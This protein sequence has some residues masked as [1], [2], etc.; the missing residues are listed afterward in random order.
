MTDDYP[1]AQAS[2]ALRREG[3]NRHEHQACA[4]ATSRS[5]PV[6]HPAKRSP[7]TVGSTPGRPVCMPACST[8]PPRSHN[9][10]SGRA[11]RQTPPTINPPYLRVCA[12]GSITHGDLFATII[13]AAGACSLMAQIGAVVVTARPAS[14]PGRQRLVP[15]WRSRETVGAPGVRGAARSLWSRGAPSC[16][17]REPLRPSGL[18]GR[19]CSVHAEAAADHP[20]QQS[21]RAIEH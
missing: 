2:S 7:S 13:I 12:P 10:P 3:S 16:T 11:G 18:S 8:N 20:P 17:Q 21:C 6:S 19:L 15:A 9:N 1:S 4:T 5:S 14:G